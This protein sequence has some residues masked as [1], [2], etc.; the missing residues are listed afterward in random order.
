MSHKN[1]TKYSKFSAEETVNFIAEPA[2]QVDPVIDE[3]ESAVIEQPIEGQTVMSEI[4]PEVI[5][6]PEPAIEPEIRKIGKVHSCTKLNV[7][8]LPSKSSS[9]VCELLVGSEIMIDEKTSTA[10]FYKICTEHGIEG[11]CMKEFVEILP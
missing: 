9:I 7:R 11:Y 10:L 8:M 4:E 1:Y 3:N 5:A 2:V 6:E